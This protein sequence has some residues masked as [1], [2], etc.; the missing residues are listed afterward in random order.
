MQIAARS[1]DHPAFFVDADFAAVF[2]A[3]WKFEL[4]RFFFTVEIDVD[5]ERCTGGKLFG[6]YH[7][8][9][10]HIFRPRA[11]LI[12]AFGAEGVFAVQEFFAF[13]AGVMHGLPRKFQKLSV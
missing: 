12:A 13:W 1:G 8:L 2:H 6:C 3:G 4:D 9:L 7:N 11:E 10:L 5:G